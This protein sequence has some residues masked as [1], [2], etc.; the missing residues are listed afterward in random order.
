MAQEVIFEDRVPPAS[1]LGTD[2]KGGVVLVE[3]VEGAVDKRK[4]VRVVETSGRRS[5]VET[6]AVGHDPSVR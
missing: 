3:N 2:T 4:T 1:P 6:R 5:E